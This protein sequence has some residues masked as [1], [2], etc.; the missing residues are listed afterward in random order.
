MLVFVL[1]LELLWFETTKGK[2]REAIGYTSQQ[3]ND[4]LEKLETGSSLRSV[5]KAYG[6]PRKALWEAQDLK[7]HEP[8]A[9]NLGRYQIIPRKVEEQIAKHVKEFQK[10]SMDWQPQMLGNYLTWL[11]RRTI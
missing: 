4:T 6:I 3:L 9:M 11:S 2:P 1:V 5:S 8:S 7:V 10:D